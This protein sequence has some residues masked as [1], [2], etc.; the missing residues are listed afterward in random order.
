L[1][2]HAT[3]NLG[4]EA[5]TYVNALDH[6]RP[7]VRPGIVRGAA[8]RFCP[9]RDEFEHANPSAS[10]APS[11]TAGITAAGTAFSL[12]EGL[13]H[14]VCGIGIVVK[15]IPATASSSKA[16]FAVVYGGP[17]NKVENKVQNHI[18]TDPLPDKAAHAVAGA[19]IAVYGKQFT[20]NTVDVVD[21][22]VQ[23]QPDC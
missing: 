12:G 5:S 22:S 4:P 3:V 23:L 17:I 2:N 18:G 8:R 10:G 11:A 15:F 9:L 19:T 7:G 1:V 20:V 14:D 13:E 6:R 16:D 21:S